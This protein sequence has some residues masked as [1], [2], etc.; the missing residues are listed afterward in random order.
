MPGPAL[1]DRVGAPAE[2]QGR[3]P[4]IH[5]AWGRV[6]ITIRTHKIKGLNESD[7]IL[8]AKIDRIER[9]GLWPRLV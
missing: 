4:D 3:H 6:R 9:R 8:A 2:E 1:V 5:L 7:F